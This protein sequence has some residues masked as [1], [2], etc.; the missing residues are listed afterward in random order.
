MSKISAIYKRNLINAIT[1]AKIEGDV[2]LMYSGGLDSFSLLMCCLEIGIRPHLYTFVQDGFMSEDLRIAKNDAQLY[3]LPLTIVTIK[4]DIH[5]AYSD[6]KRA[7]SFTKNA[8]KTVVQNLIPYFYVLPLVKEKNI[9]TG[10][11]A[12]DLWGTTRK[13]AI[14]GKT[15][16]A[17]NKMRAEALNDKT[18]ACYYVPKYIKAQGFNCIAP[19]R[20]Q[21]LFNFFKTL[22]WDDCNK[23][24]MK[25]FVYEEWSEY[26][27]QHHI[28]RYHQ[29][30]QVGSGVRETQD[31]LLS[32]TYN[33]RGA[34]V[35]AAIYNDIKNVMK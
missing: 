17:L 30:A 21:A 26:F 7:I 25:N 11:S 16:T 23:P 10:L 27:N 3:H 31:K 15:L 29:N 5:S 19:F 32:S 13:Q 20:T 35:I 12:D 34:K 8:K 9:L 4:S 24:K 22:T 1:A 6:A 28:K 2:A 33:T 14:D 18:N